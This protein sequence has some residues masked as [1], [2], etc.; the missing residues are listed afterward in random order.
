[1]TAIFL[2]PLSLFRTQQTPS[3]ITVPLHS[4]LHKYTTIAINNVLFFQMK[5]NM[6]NMEPRLLT[7]NKSLLIA[8][9]LCALLM[10]NPGPAASR[11]LPCPDFCTCKRDNLDD[12]GPV[13]IVD[14]A[15]NGLTDVPDLG[16]L[17]KTGPTYSSGKQDG[18]AHVAGVGDRIQL[19]LEKNLIKSVDKGQFPSGIDVYSLDISNNKGLTEIPENT[20]QNLAP[21][22][23]KLT[24][25][26]LALTFDSPLS[27]VSKLSKLR[28]LSI[29]HN[30]RRGYVPGAREHVTVRLLEGP[31]TRSLTTLKMTNCGLRSLAESSLEGLSSLETLDLSNNWFTKIPAALKSLT[32]LKT[33][34]LFHCYITKLPDFSFIGMTQLK[35]LHL[36]SNHLSEIEAFAFTGPAN[37]LEDLRMGRCHLTNIPTKALKVLKALKYLDISANRFTEVGPRAFKGSYCLTELLISAKGME[38]SLEAFADQSQCVVTLTIKQMELTSIPREAISQ[39]KNLRRLSLDNNMIQSLPADAFNGIAAS[40]IRLTGNP[41]SAIEEHAFRGLPTGMDINLRET[42]VSGIGFLLGY[43]EDAISSVNLDKAGLI[44]RCS[45]REALNATLM[46]NIYGSCRSGDRDIML[47]S[48]ELPRIVDEACVEESKRNAGELRLSGVI[49]WLS[50]SLSLTTF[51]IIMFG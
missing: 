43:P 21:T 22:L 12:V 16:V 13:F 38:F 39:L 11:G 15:S 51:R 14:C 6:I 47:S 1:M 46:A 37:S 36:S 26:A 3:C 23:E 50:I 49:T 9:S 41:L 30:N 28:D 7:G 42:K 35:S 2:R 40:S 33:L 31:I 5:Q 45:M 29:S 25:E 24:L 27:M 4:I 10:A 34:S 19:N 18:G 20:F 8:A 48:Q 32:S 17:M 44:C